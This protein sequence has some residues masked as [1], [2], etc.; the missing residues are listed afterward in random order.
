VNSTN[1]NGF[2]VR[3]G[4]ILYFQDIS[5]PWFS[6]IAT[7]DD[8]Q[9]MAK[10]RGGMDRVRAQSARFFFVPAMEHRR[11]ASRAR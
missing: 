2:F 4:K 11:G 7:L 5:D 8:Y 3:G 10:D 9:R 6:A 1:L